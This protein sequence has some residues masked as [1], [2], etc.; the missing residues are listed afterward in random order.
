MSHMKVHISP[1]W[2][3]ILPFYAIFES[4]VTIQVIQ[5]VI[6]VLPVILLAKICSNHNFS[7][8]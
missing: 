5:A 3:L 4:P 6:L 2:F 7:K 1:A 8:K